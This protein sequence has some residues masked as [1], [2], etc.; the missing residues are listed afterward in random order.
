HVTVHGKAAHAGGEYA[1]GRSAIKEAAHKILEIESESDPLQIT[2]NCGMIKGG[3]SPNTV[4]EFCE[5]M[6]YNRYWTMD[7][8]TQIK[9]HVEG[10]IA[11]SY[12]PET[13]SS[14]EIIGERPPMEWSDANMSLFN[15]FNDTAVKYGFPASV[16]YKTAGGSDATYTAQ[17]GVPSICSVGIHGGNCHQLSEWVDISSIPKQAKIIAAAIAEM[18]NG[19][20][21]N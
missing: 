2:Y 1:K 3:T 11:K 7:Q 13:E 6:L 21:I 4:P 12:I 9:D 19:F 8:R 15:L 16:P 5:F 17:V 18:P 10:I 14:F 20:G